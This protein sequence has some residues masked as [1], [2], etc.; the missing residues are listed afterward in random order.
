MRK[1]FEKSLS[2][3]GRRAD[4]TSSTGS[5]GRP[6]R[7]YIYSALL[8]ITAV[9]LSCCGNNK[10]SQ[11]LIGTDMVTGAAGGTTAQ[12][13]VA[14]NTLELVT[15]SLTAAMQSTAMAGAPA[16]KDERELPNVLNKHNYSTLGGGL[17]DVYITGTSSIT[18][19]SGAENELFTEDVV[20][21]F[22]SVTVAV[23]GRNY[24]VSG[25]E[26]GSGVCHFS[27]VYSS[28]TFTDT[29]KTFRVE[30]SGSI[31]ISGADCKG[32]WSYDV[33]TIKTISQVA[34]VASISQ[35][36][37]HGTITHDGI[38]AGLRWHVSETL[39]EPLTV[40]MPF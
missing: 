32:T 1:L 11:K 30:R 31:T 21:T 16:Y 8:L 7:K 26:S 28:G 19:V 24:M 25:R 39:T 29:V 13:A 6:V 9:A 14:Q 33:T 34:S 35:I 2:N 4:N 12:S 20:T 17:L 36:M 23:G 27:L 15:P 18:F 37:L 38:V 5:A 22:S 40:V 3:T 10:T